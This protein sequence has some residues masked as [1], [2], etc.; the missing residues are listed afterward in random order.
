MDAALPRRPGAHWL[1]RRWLG[2][3]GCWSR[4]RASRPY[5]I[6]WWAAGDGH[7]ES[8]LQVMEPDS[9]QCSTANHQ[10]LENGSKGGREMS[11]GFRDEGDDV[12]RG[13]VEVGFTLD[14]RWRVSA[15]AESEHTSR[16]E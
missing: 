9:K 6:F 14:S 5:L 10:A 4:W 2:W 11:G 12:G 15:R 8:L 7:F 13:V 1:L 16:N 3:A